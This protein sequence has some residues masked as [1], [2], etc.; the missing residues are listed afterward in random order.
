MQLIG[1]SIRLS[2][3]LSNL[4]FRTHQLY[5]LLKIQDLVL[6]ADSYNPTF[7][8]CFMNFGDVRVLQTLQMAE[9]PQNWRWKPIILS[10]VCHI[11]FN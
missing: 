2:F 1:N 6:K 8:F 7:N 11:E 3:G 9:F 10:C 4:L 5:V